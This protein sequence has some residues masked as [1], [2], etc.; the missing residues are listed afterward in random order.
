MVKKGQITLFIII[1]LA[2]ILV[3]GGAVFYFSGQTKA[4]N[5]RAV[6]DA[7]SASAAG[8]SDYSVVNLFVQECLE[9]S[10]INGIFD[11]GMQGGYYNLP[12]QTLKTE[13]GEIPFFYQNGRQLSITHRKLI[14]EYQDYI[15]DNAVK[16]ADFS[17]LK[18]RG[19][20]VKAK[21]PEV[22]VKLLNDEA[23]VELT[24]PLTIT[25]DGT[26]KTMEK[27]TYTLPFGYEYVF[28]MYNDLISTIAENPKYKDLT[29]LVSFTDY[30]A[31]I[32]PVNKTTDIYI[33]STYRHGIEERNER[34]NFM[35]AVER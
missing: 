1:A 21:E 34:Y 28:F 12:K 31:M 22:V 6:R 25:K 29:Q 23:V 9:M 20:T 5:D 18:K 11:L 3:I 13:K 33:L 16:C 27:W 14:T 4:K 8:D 15:K 2:V 24:Y 17:V 26:K 32:V 10:S 19:I 35:F 30:E 7:I